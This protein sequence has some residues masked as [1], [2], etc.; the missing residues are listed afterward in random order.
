MATGSL[1][2]TDLYQEVGTGPLLA[3]LEQGN[4]ALF[5]IAASAPAESAPAHSIFFAPGVTAAFSY[6]GSE[7]VYAKR[8]PAQ[9]SAP[10]KTVISYTEV[11]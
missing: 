2:L 7:N 9:S 3:T 8:S 4:R 6:S 11:V 1:E 10:V 5:H